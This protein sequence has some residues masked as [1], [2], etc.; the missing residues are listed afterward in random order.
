MLIDVVVQEA[1]ARG[2]TC[3]RADVRRGLRNKCVRI[4]GYACQIVPMQLYLTG[5]NS[6]LV[7]HCL[8]LPRSDWPDFI[9]YVFAKRK[10]TTRFFIVPRGEISK[11]TTVCAPNNWLFKYENAWPLLSAGIASERLARRFDH[12]PWKLWVVIRKARALGLDVQLVGTK[13]LASRHIKDRL[14]INSCKC[15]VITAG[16]FTTKDHTT[17]IINLYAP[18]NRWADFLIFVVPDNVEDVF[19][20][21]RLKI[22]RRTSTTLPS[23]WLAEYADNWDAVIARDPAYE[24]RRAVIDDTTVQMDDP[25]V[26]V[27]DTAL[28]MDDPVAQAEVAEDTD[29]EVAAEVV[30]ATDTDQEIAEENSTAPRQHEKPKRIKE[31]RYP[32]CVV[33]GGDVSPTS[34]LCREC[35]KKGW[36]PRREHDKGDGLTP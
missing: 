25:V 2:L 7:D 14:L 21:P 19:I 34:I 10:E 22:T 1:Q 26:Q 20:V 8:Y 31:K 4:A 15:Q 17:P 30:Q 33:C 23:K 6:D 11:E 3:T 32:Q 12:T 13:K 18:K 28:Q 16:V 5:K 29:Q 24:S 36:R 27:D 35:F 9:I